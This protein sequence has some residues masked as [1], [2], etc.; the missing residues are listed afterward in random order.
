ML[1]KLK[2]NDRQNLIGI[3]YFFIKCLI[4]VNKHF[5][6]GAYDDIMKEQNQVENNLNSNKNDNNDNT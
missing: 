5:L 1:K 6:K 4:E 2:L 3:R